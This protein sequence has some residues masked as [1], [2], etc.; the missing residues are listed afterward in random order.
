[1]INSAHRRFNRG[2]YKSFERRLR[3]TYNYFRNFTFI[4]SACRNAREFP[5]AINPW[6]NRSA[7]KKTALAILLALTLMP[8]ASFAQVVIRIGPPA[9]IVERRPPPPDRGYVWIDGYHR[10]EG[11]QYIWT[12]G[13]WDRPPHPGAHWV[14]HRWVHRGDHWVL[15]EG[16]W[17]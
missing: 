17:R 3:L 6:R 14:A 1:M 12:P 4:R 15:V 5:E 8:A 11:G 10:Y 13:R 7:M 2:W 9:P 16:H